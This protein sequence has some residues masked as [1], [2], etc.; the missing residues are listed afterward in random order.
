MIENVYTLRFMNR[1]DKMHEYRID[2]SGLPGIESL[3]DQ[4]HILLDAG[5]IMEV[6]VRV[7]ADVD[8]LSTRSEY[9]EFHVTSD[10]HP[11]LTITKEARFLGPV[12]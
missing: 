6:P 8:T 4:E 2:V 12:Q 1:N 3:H 5:Q 9:I 7:R 10:Q 11:E